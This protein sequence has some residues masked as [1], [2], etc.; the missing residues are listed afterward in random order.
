[1]QECGQFFPMSKLLTA[2]CRE[3]HGGAGAFICKDC[4]KQYALP[5]GLQQHRLFHHIKNGDFTC[6]KCGNVYPNLFKLK[7]HIRDV[8]KGPERKCPY[9][10]KRLGSTNSLRRHI[11]THT[12][13]YNYR[14]DRCG[15]A[16]RDNSNLKTHLLTHT[17]L[18]PYLCAVEDCT[19]GFHSKLT[20]IAHYKN[21][22]NIKPENMPKF[23][24]IQHSADLLKLSNINT[25]EIVDSVKAIYPTTSQQTDFDALESSDDED[26]DDIEYDDE[27]EIPESFG[28]FE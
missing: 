10:N 12:G 11:K 21:D 18:K 28:D 5:R 4:G 27:E 7:N 19:S 22:H 15:K 1:M 2:H 9:C 23:E 14:C 3:V 16:C 8:H 13:N 17:A 26:E 6:E 20:L 24:S 25:D